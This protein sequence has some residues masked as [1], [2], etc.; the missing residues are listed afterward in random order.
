MKFVVYLSFDGNCREAF[1]F[2]ADV[3]GG[4]IVNMVT[5]GETE[6]RAHVP[7]DWHDRIINAHLVAGE[8]ELMGA[9][10]PPGSGQPSGF[11]VS[12]QLEDA[13]QGER[14]FNRFAEGGSVLMPFEKTFWAERFGMVTDR[15]DTPW[16]INCGMAR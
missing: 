10:S 15:F 1:R 12:I 3:F 7:E 9:D 16:M 2:Y 11:S 14:I 6:V 4:T 5:H 13:A 8:A